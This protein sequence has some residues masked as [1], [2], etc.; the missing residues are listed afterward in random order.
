MCPDQRLLA[1]GRYR[2]ADRMLGIPC[3]WLGV[4]AWLSPSFGLSAKWAQQ[5]GSWRLLTRSWL[6]EAS[7]C[8]SPWFLDCWL[9][10]V[11]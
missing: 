11:G 1:W 5:S 9:E 10:A 7:C 8:G 2:Q 4:P 3:D 6:V